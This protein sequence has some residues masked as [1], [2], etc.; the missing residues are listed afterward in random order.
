VNAIAVTFSTKRL[1]RATRLALVSAL[2]PRELARLAYPE[3][4][5]PLVVPDV[6]FHP[7]PA[8]RR[9]NI[10]VVLGFGSPMDRM[11]LA[12]QRSLGPRAGEIEHWPFDDY[13]R[14]A[15]TGDFDL[16]I[17]MPLAWPESD[18]AI[19]W[20][21]NSPLVAHNYSNPKVDAAIDGGDWAGALKELANDPP[22]AFI[23]LPARFAI[24]DRRFKNARIGP[25]GFFESLPDWEVE[26]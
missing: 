9:L 4:C 12:V 23:C 16:L 7:L 17:E 3:G 2:Q 22:V 1:D 10:G 18:R 20:R 15:E 5:T 19:L 24:I 13:R 21:T 11:A 26:R 25:Y 14:R 8:G 6:P